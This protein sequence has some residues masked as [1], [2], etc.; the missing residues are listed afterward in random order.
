MID[1]SSSQKILF[2]LVV[3]VG[4]T[5]E[6]A[7][8]FGATIVTVTLSAFFLP[9]DRILAVFLPVNIAL[10]AFLVA[11]HRAAVSARLLVLGI[12]PFMGAG[13]IAALLVRNLGDKRFLRTA[14]AAFVVALAA[15]ELGLGAKPEQKRPLSPPMRSAT[16]F[17]AGVI[18][19]LFACGGPMVVYVTAREISDKSVFRATL[20]ALW[21]V[22]NVVLVGTMSF[23]GEVSAATLEQSLVL[24]VSLGLGALLGEH[25]HARVSEATF[26]KGVFVGLVAAGSI[27]FLRSIS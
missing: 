17:G 24:V 16:L 11:R 3:L 6:T 19:G 20:C 2:A 4:F 12:L 23:A 26:R 7:A 14:F 13:M 10:S 5:V 18:H 21:L 8:G 27:L 9:I 22:L 25:V 1:A 15:V